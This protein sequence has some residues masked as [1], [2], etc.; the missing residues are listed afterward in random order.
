MRDL[1][2]ATQ[3]FNQLGDHWRQQPSGQ[4]HISIEAVFVLVG[5]RCIHHAIQERNLL[6]LQM[7]SQS[8]A[9]LAVPA[10]GQMRW[11]LAFGDV[12]T[13]LRVV[14][15]VLGE[16]H[17]SGIF[18][19]GFEHA[20]ALDCEGA[21]HVDVIAQQP[22]GHRAL[23]RAHRL[24][25]AHRDGD[26]VQKGA[27]HFVGGGLRTRGDHHGLGLGINPHRNVLA[28]GKGVREQSQQGVF[29]ELAPL[30]LA[31]LAAGGALNGVA[32]GSH[33]LVDLRPW[34]RLGF[35]GQSA[36]QLT[37]DALHEQAI[38]FAAGRHPAYRL[39]LCFAAGHE[40]PWLQGDIKGDGANF[41]QARD[42]V[43]KCVVEHGYSYFKSDQRLIRA[44]M[45][46]RAGFARPASMVSTLEWRGIL[47]SSDT[48]R[49]SF[50]VFKTSVI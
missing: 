26:A 19:V 46:S 7:L 9:H 33:Q 30:F 43:D 27:N 34:H 38:G 20:L 4:R 36:D 17:C 41:W 47:R 39:V 3:G 18:A 1:H 28:L 8:D 32:F 15:V 5:A 37:C 23:R 6:E 42:L 11:Q 13:N 10:D 40:Y 22:L 14:E 12:L 50:R 45:R 21:G 2:L 35:D 24:D 44:R 49:M 25:Q 29:L 48:A 31:W 16:L